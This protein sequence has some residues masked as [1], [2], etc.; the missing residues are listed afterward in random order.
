MTD[1]WRSPLGQLAHSS[2]DGL[3]DNF[4][5]T[6]CTLPWGR[7]QHVVVILDGQIPRKNDKKLPCGESSVARFI[8]FLILKLCSNTNTNILY[9][10]YLM[11]IYYILLVHFSIL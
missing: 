6:L 2:I 9:T 1:W 10:T 7:S 5:K 3:A 4:T 11:S 8:L